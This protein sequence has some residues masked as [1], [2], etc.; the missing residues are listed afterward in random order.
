[1]STPLSEDWVEKLS[2]YCSVLKIA[3]GDITFKPVIE[4]AAKSG[5]SV[6]LS[7]GGSSVE[8]IDRAVGWIENIIGK[9]NIKNKLA[10]MHCVSSYPTPA[11]QAN[12][13]SVPFLKERYK[14]CT[15]YSNHVLG[16][17]PCL[18][19]VAHGAQIVEVHFTDKK[20]DRSFRDHELSLNQKELKRL[21]ELNGEIKNC[22]GNYG[23]NLRG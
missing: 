18:A 17:A 5:K 19:A 23:K 2:S 15:G 9:Q 6:I 11:N 21:I 3:S 16:L 13:L 8:E 14:L 12:I 20:E 22:I 7:T 10:I 1:M 4:N